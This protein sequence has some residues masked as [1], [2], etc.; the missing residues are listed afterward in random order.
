MTTIDKK[1]LE[2]ILN[3][4]AINMKVIET[5]RLILRTWAAHDADAY[6][7]INQD[8][9]V[10]EFLLGPITREQVNAFI[11]SSIQSFNDHRFCLFAVALKENNALIGFIGL[12]IPKFEAHFTPCVEIGWRLSSQHW[13]KGYATEGARAVLDYGF[14]TIGLGEIVAFTVPANKRAI[15][16]MEKLS[17]KRDLDGDFPHPLVTE[18]HPLSHHVLYKV[19]KNS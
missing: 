9:R 4:L 6:F 18:G 12:S 17:M 11:E 7:R 19:S 10:Y 15:Q 8:P 13:G 16:V 2:L 5:E 1:Q 3:S 14:N